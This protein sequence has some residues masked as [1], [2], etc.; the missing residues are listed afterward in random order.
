MRPRTL[1]PGRHSPQIMREV[2]PVELVVDELPDV[3]REII[4]SERGI[5][6]QQCNSWLFLSTHPSTRGTWLSRFRTKTRRSSEVLGHGKNGSTVVVTVVEVLVVVAVVAAAVIVV[7]LA[8]V[9]VTINV[10]LVIVVL[11]VLSKSSLFP[12]P[13]SPSPLPLERASPTTMQKRRRRAR[14]TIRRQCCRRMPERGLCV[15]HLA[16]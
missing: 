14:M 4:V 16:C 15:G 12:P 6:Q 1:A 9:L 5:N 8:V 13:T 7:V 2:D 3:P 10:V 11:V